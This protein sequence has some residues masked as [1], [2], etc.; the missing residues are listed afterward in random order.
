MKDHSKSLFACSG[1]EKFPTKKISSFLYTTFSPA[2]AIIF[3]R[4]Y[5]F[6]IDELAKYQPS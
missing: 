4:F 5:F 6:I 3:A 1:G 2:R